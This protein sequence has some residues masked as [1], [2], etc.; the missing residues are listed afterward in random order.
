MANFNVTLQVGISKGAMAEW[1]YNSSTTGVGTT[2]GNP[3]DLEI[4]DTVTFIRYQLGGGRQ[5]S[6]PS[7]IYK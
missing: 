4:G 7:D 3:L 6:W 5:S 1:S 2:S